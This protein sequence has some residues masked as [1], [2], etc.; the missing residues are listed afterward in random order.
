M[1]GGTHSWHGMSWF[2]YL[3][4]EVTLSNFQLVLTSLC[5]LGLSCRSGTLCDS[6]SPSVKLVP[7]EIRRTWVAERSALELARVDL[8]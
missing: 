1:R 2:L 7:R 5:F 6:V 8:M 3:Q 4:S